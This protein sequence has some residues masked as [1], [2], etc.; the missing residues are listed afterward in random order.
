MFIVLKPMNRSPVVDALLTS[1][2]LF[3]AQ[4][5]GIMRYLVIHIIKPR[6]CNVY[7]NTLAV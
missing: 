7:L 2:I 5:K 6:E 3:F 4:W 1:Q